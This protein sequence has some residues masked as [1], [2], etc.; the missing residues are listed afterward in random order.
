MNTL[1]SCA[2]EQG[3]NSG[4]QGIDSP[5]W[6]GAGNW[7]EIDSRAPTGIAEGRLVRA[8][9][10]IDSLG[11]DRLELIARRF[12]RVEGRAALAPFDGG[13]ITAPSVIDHSDR[14]RALDQHSERGFAP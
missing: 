2:A 7:S 6:T 14:T 13:R 1:C 10:S 8:E 12:A 3:I 9:A 4:E 5:F 11:T